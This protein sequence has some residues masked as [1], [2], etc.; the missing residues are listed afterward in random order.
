MQLDGA[1]VDFGAHLGGALAGAAA[2]LALMVFVLRKET[3]LQVRRRSP[4]AV[5]LSG[6]F[7]VGVA[8]AAVA[9]VLWSYPAATTLERVAATLLPNEDLPAPEERLDPDRVSEWL[10][11][12]PDD[13]RVRLFAA[14][15]AEE[16]ERHEEAERQLALFREALSA[17]SGAFTPEAQGGLHVAAADIE[18]AMALRRELLPNRLLPSG[19]DEQATAVWQISLPEWLER[20]PNDPRVLLQAARFAFDSG[21]HSRAEAHAR[22]GLRQAP[23]FREN[24]P[25]DGPFLP[26]LHESLIRSVAAQGRDGEA[27]EM[28]EAVCG[29]AHGQEVRSGFVE[30]GLCPGTTPSD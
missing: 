29:G 27:R 10:R 25:G 20:Y 12:Y 1:R 4:V 8:T 17:S 23:R 19:T 30:A 22:E 5:A 24:F 2:G 28:A 16:E 7:L 26:G 21:D 14:E 9:V 13:P 3:D 6:L 15:V 11:R 18:D